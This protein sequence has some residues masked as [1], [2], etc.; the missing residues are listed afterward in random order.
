MAISSTDQVKGYGTKLMNKLKGN[1]YYNLE[2]I[3]SRKYQSLMT[4]ADN[5]AL[6]FFKKQGFSSE[7]RIPS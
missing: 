7:I 3:Q 2:E 5:L 6:G 4:F 1:H